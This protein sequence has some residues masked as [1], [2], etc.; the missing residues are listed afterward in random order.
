[1][2]RLKALLIV[3]SVTAAVAL[4]A[5]AADDVCFDRDLERMDNFSNPPSRGDNSFF[6]F[7]V[8]GTAN[9][10]ML[11]PGTQSMRAH[12]LSLYEIWNAGNIPPL[13]SNGSGLGCDST[14]LNA[15][16]Y[17]MP[18]NAAAPAAPA[19]LLGTYDAT[20]RY[21]EPEATYAGGGG[22]ADN[23]ETS[24]YSCASPANSSSCKTDSTGGKA[25]EFTLW[26]ANDSGTTHTA[27]GSTGT[28][29]S[30]CATATGSTVSLDYQDCQL[31]VKS[32]GYW[33]NSTKLATNNMDTN[34]YT[35]V[36]KGNWLNFNPPKWAI[37]RL[38]YKRLV[39]GPLLN[40]LREGIVT[41]CTNVSGDAQYCGADKGEYRLQKM[42]PQSCS[43][44]GRPSQRISSVDPVNYNST[45]NPLS[46]MLFNVAW[47]VSAGSNG[48]PPSN[49]PFF[50]NQNTHPASELGVSG[51]T[52]SKDGFCPGCN[53]GF[54]IVFSDGRGMDG[55]SNCDDPSNS[56]VPGVAGYPAY[57]KNPDGSTHNSHA[58]CSGPNTS[59]PGLGLGAEHDGDDYINPNLA[60]GA[61]AP[62]SGTAVFSGSTPAGTCPN[63]YVDDVAGW[64]FKN[65]MYAP[66]A[67][68]NL[69]L[70]AVE[71][72]TNVF[73]QMNSLNAAAAA[74]GARPVSATNFATLEQS[75]TSVFQEIISNATS[76]SVAAI[77]T[78]QTRGTTF[79]FIPRFRPLLGSQWE[80][81]LYRFRL[82]NEFAAG[83]SNIDL[84]C[85]ADGGP[86]V[87]ALNPNGNNSCN[88]IYLQDAD[89]GFVGEDDGGSFILLDTS[90]TWSPTT[91]FPPLVPT[92]PARPV[93]EAAHI[94]D[95]RE[96]NLLMGL[97][98]S[99]DD[100]GTAITARAILT[101]PLDAG[102]PATGSAL[103]TFNDFSDAGVATM[104]NYMKFSGVNSDYCQSM[105]LSTRRTYATKEDCG[106]DTMKFMDGQDV[107]HQNQDG[108]LVR[109][110]ILG[111]VFHSSPI[112]VTPPVPIFLC[113]TG[114]LT[115]CVRTLYAEDAPCSSSGGGCTPGSNAAYATYLSNKFA[116]PELILVGAND[117]MVHAFHAGNATSTDGG[118]ANFDEGTGVEVWAFIPPDML[119]KLQRYVL[120]G[121]HQTLVDGTPWV[122]D[123]WKDGSGASSADNQKQADEFH[124][125]AIVGER[126][127][128]RSYTALDVTDT[129]RPPRYLWTWPPL[130]S[131]YELAEGESWNDTT[132]NPPPIGP[133]LWQDN[134]GPISITVPASGMA[135][136]Q[137]SRADERWVVVLS[138]GYD[139]N[140]IRGRAVYVLDAWDGTLLYKFSRYDTSVSTDPRFNLG[141]VAAAVS[142]VDTNF[143][144]FF[145]LGVV[146]D[147]EGNLFT[148]D[149]FNPLN[150]SLTTSNWFG[151]M[152]FAQ[153]KGNAISQRSP[154]FQMAGARVFDDTKGGVRIYTGSGDR[155]Q[156][157]VRDTDTA[158]GG[159]CEVDNLRGCI[160]NNCTVDVTQNL[161]QIGDAGLSPENLAG[162][163]KYGG[164][165]TLT[166]NTGGGA[167]FTLSATTGA[168]AC[169]DPAQV[170]IRYQV[171][172]NGIA[173]QDLGDG[174]STV[175]NKVYCDFDGG[176]ALADGG[177][178]F[179][180]GEECP[181][182]SGKP[183]GDSVSF[184]TYS[185]LTNSRFYSIKL[186]DAPAYTNR[187]RMT[188]ASNQAT[189]NSN[190]L[191]DTNLTDV[192][193]DAGISSTAA[194]W[195]IQQSNDL[196][197]KTASG[198]LLLGGCVAWNTLVSQNVSAD[199]GSAC[200]GGFIPASTAYLYQANDD[201]GVI[202]CGLPGSN[203]QLATVRF[204]QRSI[205]ESVP[206]QPTP[207]VSLN[208]KTG[209]A[210][211]SGVSLEPGGKIPLQVSVGAASVQGDVSWL[212]VSRNL[213]NCRHPPDG[214]TPVCN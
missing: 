68:T 96:N 62:I 106:L 19:S 196:N 155:D 131:S 175:G 116:R 37:L 185:G 147:T 102:V 83:C 30:E 61:I 121:S 173:M 166:T 154:F 23:F 157:R 146:G 212:D 109:P 11:Y 71:I 95:C 18:S 120:G 35:L 197:E 161:Y 94:L 194:G 5:R 115:Q 169:T 10:T 79:A 214:G 88:D 13:P 153:F 178:Q 33:L 48:S 41:N 70:Y 160:R 180:A 55:W 184:A 177:T 100:G 91:G 201:T 163:W 174:G 3:F 108:G 14:T 85:G 150:G 148:I 24:S 32:K 119:P 125:I 81:R 141:P 156:I 105:S 90:K 139:P 112:L 135:A 78:V 149:M 107:L 152:T 60:G 69:K 8:S 34:P 59:T 21:P 188:I 165:S 182:P 58:A 127:G 57:C 89:G 203:T 140:L 187:P 73:G 168:G 199:G 63:D 151:G 164:G 43:G 9:V 138:G 99:C 76:F 104:T 190:T 20:K 145:D 50:S 183:S 213:H 167:T 46:E 38:A 28:I 202:Q 110:N 86:C 208:A 132:P 181:D 31:C 114:L 49:W 98:S 136:A 186:F 4:P 12:P 123:I 142:M 6:T 170:D 137:T 25:W 129:T 92:T 162:E 40:P 7:T 75:I 36:A 77:T 118:V 87:T 101:T 143:D 171:N 15:L 16:P 122:R 80:G 206:Q 193:T 44:A 72:G 56:Q 51:Q 67:G 84:T 26:P 22:L 47:T 158:D 172:C 27:A 65:N 179:D 93:W 126:G 205:T 195:F 2:N 111:D 45:A 39:N 128:G 124:T 53:S 159:T 211:Y 97:S 82:F 189:Y 66:Q 29:D 1:M 200:G 113:E 204:T 209:Q 198:A 74:G 133:I 191:T 130:G 117:G 134:A 54:S 64:M 52:N 144:N 176:L 207:V 210:G 17:F 192:S 103:V 42:L